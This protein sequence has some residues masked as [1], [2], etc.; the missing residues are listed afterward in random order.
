MK[1]KVLGFCERTFCSHVFYCHE[2]VQEVKPHDWT[3]PQRPHFLTLFHWGLQFW[4]VNWGGVAHTDQRIFLK[5]IRARSPVGVLGV[6]G[7]K[8]SISFW[9]LPWHL[10]FENFNSETWTWFSSILSTSVNPF[11]GQTLQ[12]Y[13]RAIF[14]IS[15]L[16]IPVGSTLRITFRIWLFLTPLWLEPTKAL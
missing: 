15:S 6:L 4:C 1:K 8:T 7:F 12:S 14:P 2:S 16:T 9:I 13:P 11:S 10:R 5:I 3:S